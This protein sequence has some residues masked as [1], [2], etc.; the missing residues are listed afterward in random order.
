MRMERTQKLGC[1][2]LYTGY[3]PYKRTYNI[4]QYILVLRALQT[5]LSVERDSL[6]CLTLRLR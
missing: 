5:R 6:V 4:Y 2:H 3:F 1:P